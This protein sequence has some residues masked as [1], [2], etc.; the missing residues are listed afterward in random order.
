MF[1]V[2]PVLTLAVSARGC[3]LVEVDDG[4]VCADVPLTKIKI[5]PQS[6]ARIRWDLFIMIFRMYKTVGMG[7]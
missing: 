1:A 7:I 5:V 2:P 3:V 6:A 4:E